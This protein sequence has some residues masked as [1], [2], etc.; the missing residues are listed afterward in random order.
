[1]R[2]CG[3]SCRTSSRIEPPLSAPSG[4]PITQR[5]DLWLLGRHKV[6]CGSA[7]DAAAY[8]VLLG[9]E[10]SAA[11]FTDPPY[12]VPIDGHVSGL[13]K[14]HHREFAMG[15]GEMDFSTFTHFLE[16]VLD[17]VKRHAHSGSLAYVCMD[18]SPA[19]KAR[20]SRP[21]HDSA[22]SDVG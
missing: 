11:V 19:Q 17:L 12:N 9:T 13:G 7:L 18:W 15:S 21:R 5:G 14:T 2:N 3:K 22:G 20:L 4:P 6:F 8:Y 10:K 16:T 1:M